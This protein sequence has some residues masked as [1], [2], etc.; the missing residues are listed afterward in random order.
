MSGTGADI[1]AAESSKLRDQ[2]LRKRSP[3]ELHVFVLVWYSHSESCRILRIFLPE[4]VLS[5][6]FPPD[7]QKLRLDCYR[8]SCLF[9]GLW[10][11]LNVRPVNWLHNENRD[12]L[13]CHKILVMW[14]G[15]LFGVFPSFSPFQSP[16]LSLLF[17]SL[18][19]LFISFSFFPPCP[20][21]V[22]GFWDTL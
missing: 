11:C 9:L 15:F 19:P 21:T 13:C 8:H 12:M 14:S 17:L 5:A 16:F 22:I 20:F 6:T 4:F 1:L 7:W 10:L 3:S 2:A 18:F